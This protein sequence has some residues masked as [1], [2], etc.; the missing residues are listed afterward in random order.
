MKT[1][2]RCSGGPQHCGLQP[3]PLRFRLG[4]SA[5]WPAWEPPIPPPCHLHNTPS[6]RTLLPW[7]PARSIRHSP[8]APPSATPPA[9]RPFTAQ[10]LNSPKA[11]AF[12]VNYK[13]RSIPCGFPFLCFIVLHVATAT[14][15]TRSPSSLTHTALQHA[16]PSRVQSC[17]HFPLRDGTASSC[18]PLATWHCHT[19]VDRSSFPARSFRVL[20]CGKR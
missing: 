14:S 2:T 10:V 16:V 15:D 19:P 8:P 20:R 18:C 9:A 13:F 3:L 1:A 11:F 5:G 4:A 12:R 6:D 17:Q 7:G